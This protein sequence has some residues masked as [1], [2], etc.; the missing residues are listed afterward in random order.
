MSPKRMHTDEVD[1]DE[2]LVR[3]L[4]AEQF[5]QWAG[6]GVRRVV[7]AGTDNA[8]FRLGDA[9]AVRLPRVARAMPTLA[10]ELEWLPRLA[11]E[12]PLATPVPVAA[13]RAGEGY[14]FPWAVVRWLEG[15]SLDTEP[16]CDEAG[17]ARRLAEFLRVL[18]GLDAT[19]G[20][21]PGE[22]NFGRGE[23]LANR[24]AA[25][26]EG[27]AA[28]AGEFDPASLT[29][30]WEGALATPPWGEPGVWI[31][32]DLLPG[33]LLTD[34]GVLSAVI[35]FGGLGIGDPACDAMAAWTIFS[36]ESRAILRQTLAP[37]TAT[38][39]RARGWALSWAA[40]FI[41]YY[42]RTNPTGVKQARRTLE[43]VLSD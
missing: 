22:H 26:R 37:D 21:L 18:Q 5:P 23:P 12:L 9:L 40:I 33:N 6:L 43:N 38:W 1:V 17:A 10:K 11:P 29:E 4:L 35:D 27:I 14:P 8:L 32:G 25:T 24:D 7:S 28:L 41:P 15:E 30:I 31:H 36:A 19:G 13:G 3:S 39:S 2:A 42:R 34:D 16:P 20:P